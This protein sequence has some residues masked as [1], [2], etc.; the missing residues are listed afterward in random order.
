MEQ[1][2]QWEPYVHSLSQSNP[3]NTAWTKK[4]TSIL[5]DLVSKDLDW[6]TIAATVG[7][8]KTPQQCYEWFDDLEYICK[9]LPKR[10]KQKSTQQQQQQQQQQQRKRRKAA[11]IER[12]YKCQEKYCH[13]S[14]GTEGALKMHI[15][16]KHPAVTYNETYQQQARKAAAIISQCAI[17]QDPDEE[18]TS[19]EE[20][21]LQP[22]QRS[23]P[24]EHRPFKS[25]QDFHFLPG[26]GQTIPP[27][28]S[29]ALPPYLSSPAFPILPPSTSC[30]KETPNKRK[31]PGSDMSSLPSITKRLHSQITGDENGALSALCE[32]DT[33]SLPQIYPAQ[34]R[35][36]F[37]PIARL[38]MNFM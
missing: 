32:L 31:A 3:Q 9:H 34:F 38:P 22:Q 1:H 4:E 5:L 24:L 11:Q 16:L 2:K 13:R 27:P 30:L 20:Q 12:L 19:I 21:P 10:P 33:P 29:P 35:P 15:K 6:Q 18:E 23:E 25:W 37:Q 28:K 36:Q 8:N 14:Y 26:I 17:D 7:N